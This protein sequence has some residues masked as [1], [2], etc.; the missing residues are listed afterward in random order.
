MPERW[1]AFLLLK[2][3]ASLRWRER[4]RRSPG[5]ILI[6]NAAPSAFADSSSPW[7]ST[8]TTENRGPESAWF[9]FRPPFLPELQHHLD[10]SVGWPTRRSRAAGPL[11]R[12]N[13]LERMTGIEPALS[14]WEADVLPLNYIRL[15]RHSVRSPDVIPAVLNLR[16]DEP[17]AN[18]F[19]GTR[20]RSRF[21]AAATP[22]TSSQSWSIGAELKTC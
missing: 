21:L 1:K 18:A 14:A 12:G 4:S 13:S 22:A 15:T 9:H 10:T 17:Q 8:T 3:F 20:S 2:T 16:S 11:S 7:S 5:M 6:W 19:P